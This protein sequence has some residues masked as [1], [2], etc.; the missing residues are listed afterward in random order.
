MLRYDRARFAAYGLTSAVNGIALLIFAFD[1]S[2]HLGS[3]LGMWAA[4]AL[5]LG[6]LAWAGRC[7]MRRGRDLGWSAPMIAIAFPL[8]LF[9]M[10]LGLLLIGFLCFGLPQP[11]AER[12]GLAPPAAG[13]SRLW[14]GALFGVLAPWALLAPFALAS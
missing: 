14:L 3:K 6:A 11:K 8:S 7:A 1:A 4:I 9:L 5:G 2:F 10:P 13:A 12:F